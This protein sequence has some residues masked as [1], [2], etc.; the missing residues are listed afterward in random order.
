[1]TAY[2]ITATGTDIGKTFV[3]AGILR[4]ARTQ[5]VPAQGFKPL[6]SDFTPA[7][8]ETSDAGRI[9]RAMGQD[10]T[11]VALDAITPWRYTAALSPDMAAAREGKSVEY[12]GILAFSRAA[13]AGPGLRLIEGVGGVMVPLDETRTVLDWMADLALPAILVAGTYLGTISHILTA[14]AVLAARAVPLTALV[15]NETG[16]GAV[17]LTDTVAALGRFLPGIPIFTLPRRPDEATA[18]VADFSPLLA[19]LIAC[20]PDSLC[21]R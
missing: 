9:L 6:L 7:R 14:A 4:A 16:D 15:L 10:V 20:P 19:H 18:P 13:A 21:G 2:F 12:D 8:A 11:P 5:G 1:M 3:S 17:P